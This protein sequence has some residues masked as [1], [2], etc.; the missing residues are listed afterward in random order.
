MLALLAYQVPAAVTWLVI[1][2]DVAC[3]S[4]LQWC[5]CLHMVGVYCMAWVA[6]H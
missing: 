4:E 6:M 5:Q 3:S 1:L 2:G